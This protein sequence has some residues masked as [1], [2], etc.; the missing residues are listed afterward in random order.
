MQLIAK[1]ENQSA[2]PPATAQKAN[3][4]SNGLAT[5]LHRT[6]F[7][8]A[9]DLQRESFPS[10]P[11]ITTTYDQTAEFVLKIRHKKSVDVLRNQAGIAQ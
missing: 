2:S 5:T 7:A 8:D 1:R 9:L 3:T 4:N 11:D 10:N 6:H